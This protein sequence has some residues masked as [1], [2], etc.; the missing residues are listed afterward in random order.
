MPQ[1]PAA[2][3]FPESLP[4]SLMFTCLP[5]EKFATCGFG[6]YLHSIDKIQPYVD[7]Y[8]LSK[9]E[10]HD[11]QQRF[12]GVIRMTY[13]S[14]ALPLFSLGGALYNSI[15]AVV[16]GVF[17][18]QHIFTRKEKKGREER[19]IHETAQH[20]CFA[21]I[22]AST[23]LFVSYSGITGIVVSILTS[24]ILSTYHETVMGR[25]IVAE[26]NIL[27]NKVYAWFQRFGKR[28]GID[29]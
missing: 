13:T 21:L 14:L 9:I 6:L 29:L 5:K 10:N 23:L 27:D 19:L 17:V 1:A 11:T 15:C 8:V 12:L 3:L 2:I 28:L 18:S 22:D 4:C 26:K 24:A 7:Y 20:V 25:Y 16:K